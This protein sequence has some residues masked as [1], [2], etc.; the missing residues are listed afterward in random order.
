[1]NGG[2][3]VENLTHAAIIGSMAYFSTHPESSYLWLVPAISW[4]GQC[5]DAPSMT[6]QKP[7]PVLKVLPKTVPVVEVVSEV[8]HA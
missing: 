3:V 2:K 8:P 7:P 4:L 5:M 6:I 1:M